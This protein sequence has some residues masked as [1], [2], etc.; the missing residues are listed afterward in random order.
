MTAA[1]YQAVKSGDA[2]PAAV[3]SATATLALI[4]SVLSCVVSVAAIAFVV[5]S[6]RN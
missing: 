2:P 5:L 4:V 6:L 1:T 3:D